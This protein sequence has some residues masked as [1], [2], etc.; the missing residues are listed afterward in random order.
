MSGVRDDPSALA[1]QA[2]GNPNF[3]QFMESNAG[4]SIGQV[5]QEN[6]EQIRRNTGMDCNA[7]MDFLRR[8][9]GQGRR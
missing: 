3:R 6:A 1:M 9:V 5:L 2:M 4:K 8:N 7:A